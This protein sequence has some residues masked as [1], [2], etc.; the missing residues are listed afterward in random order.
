MASGR[1]G[2]A[3]EECESPHLE[4][5]SRALDRS[6]A[7]IEDLLTLARKGTGVDEMEPVELGSVARECWGNVETDGETVRVEN[8]VTVRADESRLRQLLEN[9]FR[10]AVE[11]GSTSSQPGADDAVE[12]GVKAVTVTVGE[13]DAVDGFYVEDDGP[14]IPEGE[15]DRVF[16]TGYTTASD[17]TGLGLS[18]V[19]R[20]AEAHGWEI[21]ATAGE[22]GGARFEIS[23]VETAG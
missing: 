12:H 4:D 22:T 15:R 16:E 11:H 20:I 7:L 2:L 6:E 10:N 18:I 5:V 1:L 14:G 17:G 23:G 19:Q 9:L 8:D 3:R 13:L 21:T